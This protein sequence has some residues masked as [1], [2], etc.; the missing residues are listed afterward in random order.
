MLYVH[1]WL[2]YKVLEASSKAEINPTEFLILDILIPRCSSPSSL[3]FVVVYRRPHGLV[4][5]EFFNTIDN[6][7]QS[8][9]NI[10]I[11]GDFN[12]N[13]LAT[14]YDSKHLSSLINDRAMN[15]IS[16]ELAHF[17]TGQPSFLDLTIT[18]CL[19]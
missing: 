12:V 4:L 15:V 2:R 17:G 3:I 18:D 19:E 1:T 13:L 5:N 6:Y 7:M 11:V 14:S 8:F 9:K 10:I 16:S